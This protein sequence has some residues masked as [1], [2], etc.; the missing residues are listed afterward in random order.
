M[1]N[2]RQERAA[3]LTLERLLARGSRHERHIA[4]RVFSDVVQAWPGE[5]KRLW[6]K[7][8]VESC[9]GLSMRPK[10]IDCTVNEALELAENGAC[11]VFY[12]AGESREDSDQWTVVLGPA[13][14]RFL[15]SRIRDDETT[16][17]ESA[18]ALKQLLQSH[19]E[20]DQLRCVVFRDSVETV[21]EDSSTLSPIKPLDRLIKLLKPETSDIWIVVVFAFV[22]S[23]LTLATPV[24]VEALV[25]TVAFGRFVQPIVILALILFT[26]LGFQAAVRALQTYVVEIIQRRMFARVAGDLA[27]RLPRVRPDATD[28]KDMPEL[29]NRFFDV[30]TVQ[31]VAAQLMLDGIGLVLGTV[32]GMAVLGFYHP[33]LLGF[34]LFLIAAIAIIIFGL[35]RGAVKSAIKESK[36]K[37]VMAS[38]LENV[39]RCPT[40]FGTSGAVNFAVDRADRMIHGYLEARRKHFRII[41][42]QVIFALALQAIAS[43]VLLGLGG[44]LVVAGELTLGQLVAA[45]L[46]VTVIVG[47]FAKFG[48]HMESFYDLL[49]S[50][51]KLG[52]LF[53]LPTEQ[54][55]GIMAM[56]TSQP[57]EVEINRWQISAKNS[58][59]PSI[60]ASI[61]RG[62][63]T[64]VLGAGGSGKSRLCSI[65]AGLAQPTTGKITIDGVEPRQL[66]PDVLRDHIALVGEPEF[67]NGSIAEN[68]HLG[69]SEVSDSD[70]RDSLSRL[71]VLS[72]IQRMS[73]GLETQFIGG[74]GP[75]SGS[76][77]RL[78]QLARAAVGSPGL[79]IV[80]GAL[81]GLGGQDLERAV[82]FLTSP[83][84]PWTLIVTSV[85]PDLVEVFDQVIELSSYATS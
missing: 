51:D 57:H 18:R 10:A 64:L 19:A 84:Q 75:L 44:W 83:D 53:D 62:S 80:D 46:I 25:N 1:I 52:V 43:T 37:Y 29:V 24:A 74:D 85:R 38:W 2:R 4:R 7:W 20:G 79:L 69:R 77:Q 32:I 67:F 31:K 9:H 11:L 36:H 47:S 6:W 41:M 21:Q 50:V 27:F 42:R 8:F 49:A 65:L 40:A 33:W 72:D 13:G 81:D 59:Q 22:V 63:R 76:Q 45:E 70:I 15:V 23:L 61:A 66:R 14:K 60:D 78:I 34:D 71:G 17:K 58:G 56:D 16:S 68:I 28:G 48:K 39:A 12:D 55:D 30:V 73:D 82:E 54:P 35:G 5:M 26:F 3:I